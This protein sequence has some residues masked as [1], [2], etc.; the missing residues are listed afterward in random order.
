MTTWLY[1]KACKQRK[2]YNK[3]DVTKL[4]MDI[5]LYPKKKLFF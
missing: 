2:N 5:N 4:D 1:Y 3:V